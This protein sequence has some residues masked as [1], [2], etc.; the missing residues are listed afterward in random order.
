M[1]GES[2]VFCILRIIGDIAMTNSTLCS[3]VET[4]S[5]G[6]GTCDPRTSI[7]VKIFDIPVCLF[8]H[9]SNQVNGG[10]TTKSGIPMY[11]STLNVT[12]IGYQIDTGHMAVTGL[13][14]TNYQ[15]SPP[16][17]TSRTQS[18][19]TRTTSQDFPNMALLLTGDQLFGVGKGD[20]WEFMSSW[21]ATLNGSLYCAG[22]T[23]AL[24]RSFEAT[25]ND[26]V[27]GVASNYGMTRALQV[28]YV[29]P[30]MSLLHINY[31]GD[32]IGGYTL[33]LSFFFALCSYLVL[34]FLLARCSSGCVCDS[35]AGAIRVRG[36][37]SLF[38]SSST[39]CLGWHPSE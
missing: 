34:S 4:S 10:T 18:L 35:C 30:N 13:F 38:A 7:D 11:G 19:P 27:L 2:N 23:L 36:A 17:S 3:R 16:P 25:N 14:A 22:A 1:K 24:G 6:V 21:H 15:Q 28:E 26:L 33:L 20:N 29:F 8:P 9:H 39:R 5:V 12:N 32:F 31:Q 37:W